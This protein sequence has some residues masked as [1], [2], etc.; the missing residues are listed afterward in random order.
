MQGKVEISISEYNELYDKAKLVDSA[1][2]KL[3][4]LNDK[5]IAELK[6]TNKE[7]NKK[8]CVL[9]ANVITKML[10]TKVE[11]DVNFSKDIVEFVPT[12]AGSM[13]ILTAKYK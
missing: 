4:E 5:V 10:K 12:N 2:K 7:I 13:I 11:V 6:L 1:E 8:A 3:S 9:V